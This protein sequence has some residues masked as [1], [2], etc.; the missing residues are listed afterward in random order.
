MSGGEVRTPSQPEQ[1]WTCRRTGGGV[2]LESLTTK[3]RRRSE[4]II[5]RRRTPEKLD[6]K[7][8]ESGLVF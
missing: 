1:Y 5:D 3:R 7:E 4:A 8:N 6:E 2:G